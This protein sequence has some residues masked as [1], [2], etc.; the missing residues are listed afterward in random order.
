MAYN[1][2]EDVEWEEDMEESDLWMLR[3]DLSEELEAINRYQDHIDTLENEE[4]RQVLEHIRDN[5]KE[6]VAKL[7]KLIEKL[8]LTQAEKFREEGLWS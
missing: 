5:A 1:D 8:D 4:A 7:I 6:H 3:Q 2:E